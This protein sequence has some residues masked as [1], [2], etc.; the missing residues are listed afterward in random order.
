M[1]TDAVLVKENPWLLEI[2]FQVRDSGMLD[3]VKALKSTRANFKKGNI[4]HFDMSY[5]SKKDPDASIDIL[6]RYWKNNEYY[7]RKISKGNG[8]EPKGTIT[9]MGTG[10]IKS[11]EKIPEEL[12][13]DCRMQRIRHG[14]YY[15]CL[16]K[17]LDIRSDNQRP[18]P[19]ALVLDPGARTF[20]TGYDPSGYIYEWGVKDM[21]RMI[22]LQTIMSDLQSRWTLEKHDRRFRM[23]RAWRR[24]QIK[25]SNLIKEV[26][27]K[28]IKWMV[29]NFTLVLLPKFESSKMVIKKDRKIGKVT[30]RQ[31]LSWSHYKFRM[32]LLSKSREFPW[33]KVIIC[34]EAYTSKTCGRCGEIHNKLGGNKTFKCPSCLLEADRDHHAARNIWLKYLTENDRNEIIQHVSNNPLSNSNPIDNTRTYL[35]TSIESTSISAE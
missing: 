35:C 5:R 9:G 34:N 20:M 13:K 17:P 31:L 27:H 26:H 30:V 18:S 24:I 33:C 3:F 2:P 28:A 25:I 32:S 16:I 10:Y 19:R 1:N 22:R 21:R 8:K 6:K 4:K 14:I 29:E 15:L 7:T 11:R 12:Y 23:R